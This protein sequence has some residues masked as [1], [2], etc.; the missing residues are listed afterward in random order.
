MPST[1]INAKLFLDNPRVIKALGAKNATILRR[2]GGY[3]KRVMRNSMKKAPKTKV[4]IKAVDDDGREIFIDE[5]GR[6]HT[7]DGRF[8]PKSHASKIVRKQ[9]L[10]RS[11]RRGKP[12]NYIKGGLRNNIE[13]S[14]DPTRQTVVTG[15][16][17]FRSKTKPGGGMTT[18]ELLNEGGFAKLATP[19]GTEKTDFEP[20]PF[21]PPAFDAG[22]T[23]YKKLVAETPLK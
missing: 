12:P 16:S 4:V 3:T 22:I 21:T 2:T 5:K 13:F 18:P 9:R 15:P 20:H 1:S 19:G 23:F 14:F 8:L 6:M 11:S 10:G 7:A 17:A